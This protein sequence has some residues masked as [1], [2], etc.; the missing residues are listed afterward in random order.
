M[1]DEKEKW[2]TKELGREKAKKS[3]C[4]WILGF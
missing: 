4:V 3:N 2:K 1:S